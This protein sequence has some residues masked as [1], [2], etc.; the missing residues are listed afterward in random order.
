MYTRT[1][2]LTA[3]KTLPPLCIL[4]SQNPV[5]ETLHY[6]ILTQNLRTLLGTTELLGPLIPSPNGYIK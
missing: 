4:V 5:G 1:Y 6:V 2:K 3:S